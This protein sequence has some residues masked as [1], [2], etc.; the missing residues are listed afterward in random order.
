[1]QG[2]LHEI[3]I[4]S[5]LMWVEA[6]QQNGILQV[7]TLPPAF[8]SNGYAMGGAGHSVARSSHGVDGVGRRADY[9]R[10]LLLFHQGR[11]LYGTPTSGTASGTAKSS[12]ATPE[13]QGQ[14]PLERVLD[15][16]V[17]SSEEAIP[18]PY[19]AWG[20]SL[21]P[22][23]DY[24]LQ[25]IH[26]GRLSAE[27]GRHIV[28]CLTQEALLDLLPLRQG[29]FR[30]RGVNGKGL[31]LQVSSHLVRLEV[32]PLLQSLLQQLQSWKQLYPL[33]ETPDQCPILVNIPALKAHLPSNVFQPLAQWANGEISLRRI[34]RFLNR[35]SLS[36]VQAIQ[37]YLEAGYIKLSTAQP[38][39]P[40]RSSLALLDTK[41]PEKIRILWLA[42]SQN[43]A[44]P[45]ERYADLLQDCACAVLKAEPSL[46]A[47]DAALHWQPHAI[48]VSLSPAPSEAY[49]IC[50]LLHQYLGLQ[51]VPVLM[52]GLNL[53]GYLPLQSQISGAAG[54][55][56]YPFDQA[57]LWALLAQALERYYP[58]GSL[59]RLSV[60]PSGAAN[61]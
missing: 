52:L 45:W 17:R 38:P 53:D 34:A 7:E 10:W 5:L 56:V 43:T 8:P 50:T 21:C 51:T 27:Q 4:A 31:G 57:D 35:D 61:P 24:L 55:L 42:N 18:P 13:P 3:D 30:W 32:R 22:E 16:L 6:S 26:Q 9:T 48:L 15:F 33:V 28:R 60:Q 20:L 23:Y 41:I 29:R 36:V 11:L 40:D 2:F 25:L 1:M 49:E 12:L 46:T 44:A 58:Q 14:V 59:S 39:I 37:P 54:Y 19:E 47:I